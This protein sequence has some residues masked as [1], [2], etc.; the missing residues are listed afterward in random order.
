MT[1][2]NTDFF[3]TVKRDTGRGEKQITATYTKDLED[4][5]VNNS[6]RKFVLHIHHP[7]Y[8]KFIQILDILSKKRGKSSYAELLEEMVFQEAA[9]NGIDDKFIEKYF[10]GQ[11]IKFTN[12]E[13]EEDEASIDIKDVLEADAKNYEVDK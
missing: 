12:L 7:K 6:I 13:E 10:A 8:V 11:M 4:S 9:N 3:K 2:Q 5:Y 1:A